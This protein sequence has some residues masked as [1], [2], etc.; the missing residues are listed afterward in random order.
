[1]GYSGLLAGW[2]GPTATGEVEQNNLKQ[3]KSA[4]AG[5]P[6]GAES[7]QMASKNE[8]KSASNSLLV[9]KMSAN[10]RS[11]PC[12]GVMWPREGCNGSLFLLQ[13]SVVTKRRQGLRSATLSTCVKLNSR[14][15]QASTGRPPEPASK[16][17][18][19]DAIWTCRRADLEANPGLEAPITGPRQP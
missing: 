3:P 16:V 17:R 13:R 19:L 8:A 11:N 2:L 9:R 18:Y 4:S 6:K 12:P 15:A 1:M 14:C 5:W 7:G 10:T